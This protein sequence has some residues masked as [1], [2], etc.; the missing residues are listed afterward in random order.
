[1]EEER[2][3]AQPTHWRHRLHS[4]GVHLPIP[5]SVDDPTDSLLQAL[6]DKIESVTS[7]RAELSQAM[8]DKDAIVCTLEKDLESER[9]KRCNVDKRLCSVEAQLERVQQESSHAQTQMTQ[10]LQRM[11]QSMR[12]AQMRAERSEARLRSLDKT[13][14][15]LKDRLQKQL[16]K[17]RR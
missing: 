6:V 17:V 16:S 2:N 9:R 5:A 12:D 13:H 15:E 1:M 11:D 10:E 4:V 3:E 8:Q 7:Q 14:Q